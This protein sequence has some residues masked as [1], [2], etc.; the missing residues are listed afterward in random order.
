MSQIVKSE[1]FVLN[2]INYGD[3]SVIVSLYTKDFGKLSLILKGAR[4]PKSKLSNIVDP[5]NHINVVFYKKESRDIQ[6]MSG[7][8]LL[9]HFPVIKSDFEGLKYALAILELIQ[10]L[11]P[12]HEVNLRLFAGIQRIFF[13][14]DSSDELPPVLFGRF[15]I[16]F[17]T[18]M[19]Y[20]VQLEK[21][22]NCEKEL[23]NGSE[24]AYNFNI[25]VLCYECRENY[26]DSFYLKKE[27]FQYLNC[28]KHNIKVN[29]ITKEI[30]DSSINFMEK[31]LKF[32]HSDFKGIQSLK[33]YH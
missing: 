29:N 23:R 16:F 32:H 20:E 12:E 28:L 26:P 13:L 9:N 2:K 25:G 33:I 11:I 4:S 19:G 14:L 10:K 8:D 17:L 3:T 15:F 27:L 7:A 30:L 24:L 22:S 5:L 1:G 6:L 21:C 31:Y 18:E